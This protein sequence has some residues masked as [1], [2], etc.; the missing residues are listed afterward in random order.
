MCHIFNFFSGS[1]Q[2]DR[3]GISGEWASPFASCGATQE[4]PFLIQMV[5]HP[6]LEAEGGFF[7]HFDSEFVSHS[8]ENKAVRQVLREPY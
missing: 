3:T 7:P 2:D 5:I 6:I 4:Q 8:G 1:N